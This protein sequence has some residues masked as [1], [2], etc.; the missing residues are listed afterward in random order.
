MAVLMRGKKND[1]FLVRM[2]G[3]CESSVDKYHFGFGLDED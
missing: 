2:G 1:F 3:P